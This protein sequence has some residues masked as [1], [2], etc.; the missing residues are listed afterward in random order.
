M[1]E[2]SRNIE[3]GLEAGRLMMRRLPEKSSLL[4]GYTDKSSAYLKD[5]HG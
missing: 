5:S 3:E 2:Y 1:K 4:E